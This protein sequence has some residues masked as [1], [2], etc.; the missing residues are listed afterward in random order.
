MYSLSRLPSGRVRLL[1][2]QERAQLR[3]ELFSL[4]GQSEK[5]RSAIRGRLRTM[6]RAVPAL[7]ADHPGRDHFRV[8]REMA[9]SETADPALKRYVASFSR[10]VGLPSPTTALVTQPPLAGHRVVMCPHDLGI[11]PALAG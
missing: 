5:Y 1:A 8:L 2:G 4:F 6:W 9:I 10:H 11:A 7:P 3:F